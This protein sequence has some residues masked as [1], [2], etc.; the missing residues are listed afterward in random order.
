LHRLGAVA[1]P[2][3][4]QGFL[5]KN[6]SSI[7][8]IPPDFFSSMQMAIGFEQMNENSSVI[9]GKFIQLLVISERLWP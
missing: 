8:T 3:S 9:H 2:P 5:G 6:S 7:P 4:N 1:R